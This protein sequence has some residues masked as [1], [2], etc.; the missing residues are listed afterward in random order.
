MIVD[1]ACGSWNVFLA[2]LNIGKS[3]GID[4][5]ERVRRSNKLHKEFL[6]Q[7]I[8]EEIPLEEV[9]AIVSVYTWEHL[10]A[11]EIVLSR[12]HEILKKG[13]PLIIIAPQKHYYISVLT[14]ILARPLQNWAWRIIRGRDHM[15][16]PT[17]YRLCTR[18]SLAKGADAAGFDLAEYRARD[19]ASD[20]FLTIP[21]LFLLA[22]AW[23]SLVNRFEILAPL[24]SNFVAVL[25]KR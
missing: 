20:W 3:V 24:R 7:D 14:M 19:V 1:A 18:H 13:A 8:H 23:M 25:R 6:I 17:Y 4:I 9:G 11:P 2:E 21:P 22:C 16:F 12:F 10:H 5:D 15:P